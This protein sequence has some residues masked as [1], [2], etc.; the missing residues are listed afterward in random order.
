M[1]SH[2][3][4]RVYRSLLCGLLGSAGSLF[5]GPAAD[6]PKK[7]ER[8]DLFLETVNVSVVNVDVYVTD[9]KGEPIRGLSKDDFEIFENGKPVEITNFFAVQGGKSVYAPGEEP[10]PPAAAGPPGAPRAEP[11]MPEDQRL[12]LIIYID[13]FNLQPFNRNRVMRDLRAFLG[14]HVGRDDQVMLVT[15]DRELHVR[16]PFTSD[17]SLNANR[18]LE[19]EK[20]SAQGVHSASERRDALQKIQDSQSVT[21][22]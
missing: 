3:T 4:Q 8:E 14:T 1:K 17:A 20:I 10:P 7:P 2:L 22:A 6:P 5:A 13:N 16:A 21:E 18:L 12:R 9:K 15:Y 11:G 19:L